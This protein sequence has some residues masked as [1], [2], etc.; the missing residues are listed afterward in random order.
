MVS[1][2]DQFQVVERWSGLD[3]S[4]RGSLFIRAEEIYEASG[5]EFVVFSNDGVGPEIDVPLEEV[6]DAVSDGTLVEKDRSSSMH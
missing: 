4:G 3:P 6:T 2:G 5:D 1:E